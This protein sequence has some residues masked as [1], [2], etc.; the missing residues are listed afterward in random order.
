VQ[1]ASVQPDRRLIHHGHCESDNVVLHAGFEFEDAGDIDFGASANRGGASFG[2]WPASAGVSVAAKLD[3][4]PL[5]ELVAASVK[6]GP[7]QV[8]KWLKSSLAATDTLAKAGQVPKDA[9]ASIRARAKVDVPR[10][11]ELEAP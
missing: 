3:F 6:H 11:H 10:I 2:T 4:Q 7:K 1:P 8:A 5:G 9:A